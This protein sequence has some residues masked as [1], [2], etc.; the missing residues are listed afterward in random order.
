MYR[1]RFRRGKGG[2]R[3]CPLLSLLRRRG[4][5]KLSLVERGESVE[6][7]GSNRDSKHSG[8]YLTFVYTAVGMG[9]RDSGPRME[10]K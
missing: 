3:L 1:E 10:Q 2:L 8:C 4:M 6:I 5:L 7:A 9:T